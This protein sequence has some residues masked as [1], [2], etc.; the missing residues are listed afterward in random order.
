MAIWQKRSKRNA[1]GARY[2]AARKKRQFELGRSPTLTL[3]AKRRLRKLRT[4]GGNSK[5]AL[6]SEEVAN[7]LDPKTKKAVKAKISN[8]V[9]NPANRHYVRR[10][11]MTKGTVIVTDKGKAVV[12]SR[13]GQDGVVNA[14]LL[15]DK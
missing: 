1:A 9:E 5:T 6:L 11:I 15:G 7:V 4:L 3:L 13:P 12:T 2:I 8:I 14:V 10:N